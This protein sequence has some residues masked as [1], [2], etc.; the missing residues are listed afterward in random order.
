M[1]ENEKIMNEFIINLVVCYA[2]EDEVINYSTELA[3][4][5]IRKKIILAVVVNKENKG[6]KYLESGLNYS[7]IQYEI[8][9]PEKNLGYL[10]GLMFG[11]KHCSKKSEWYILSN[12]DIQIPCEDFLE[13]FIKNYK[14]DDQK[15]VIGPSVYAPNKRIYSNP[16]LRTRPSRNYYISKNFGMTFPQ[17]YELLFRLKSKIKMNKTEIKSV[18]G[19]VYAVHG[20]YMFV[21]NK[22]LQKI[23]ECADWELLYDEEQYIAEIALQ[24]NK[25]VYFD[26]SLLV[27]HME[28]ASTGM[29]NVSK[30]YNLM[31]KSNNRILKE[32]Y[33]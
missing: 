3:K 7:G 17:V 33:K 5:S 16:Y 23:V 21:K 28:G 20:S 14:N 1:I 19:Q 25:Q 22:L 15:W 30:R 24:N 4:Q 26:E 10:N 2:N 29:V 8:M 18:S 32:F 12:T 9:N 27:Y 31:K 11:F 6:I 13:K